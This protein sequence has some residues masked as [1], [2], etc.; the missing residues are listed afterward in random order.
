MRWKWSTIEC[1]DP[2]GQGY[3]SAWLFGPAARLNASTTRNVAST[4]ALIIYRVQCSSNTT[5]E[6]TMLEEAGPDARVFRIGISKMVPA[7][8]ELRWNYGYAPSY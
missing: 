6:N 8:G 7:G 3:R 1:P 2:L 5:Q 4:D